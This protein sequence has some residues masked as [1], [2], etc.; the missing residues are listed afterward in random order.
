MSWRRP[1]G[2]SGTST[3]DLA[4]PSGHAAYHPDWG[5]EYSTGFRSMPDHPS[6]RGGGS[7]SMKMAG[8]LKKSSQV[9]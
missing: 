6:A 8:D 5:V 3:I 9:P 2:R 4:L 1:Y 7:A